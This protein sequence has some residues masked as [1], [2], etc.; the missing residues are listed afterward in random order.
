MMPVQ[1]KTISEV[2]VASGASK[3]HQNQNSRF[4]K[5]LVSSGEAKLQNAITFSFSDDLNRTTIV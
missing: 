4:Q 3:P 2:L 1:D 5:Q